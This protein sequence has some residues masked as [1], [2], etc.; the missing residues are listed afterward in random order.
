MSDEAEAP[1]IHDDDATERHGTLAADE[2]TLTK[3]GLFIW[4]LTFSAC[5]SGLL[6]GYECV[7]SL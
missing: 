1:L 4:A 7:K 2:T 3:P 5:I 6:F